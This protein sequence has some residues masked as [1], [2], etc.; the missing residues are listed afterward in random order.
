MD[1][2]PQ[3]WSRFSRPHTTHIALHLHGLD[4]INL[5]LPLFAASAS[6]HLPAVG[7]VSLWLHRF[8]RLSAHREHDPPGKATPQVPRHNQR[9]NIN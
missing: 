2:I 4:R 1:P 8:E 9:I 3:Q 7:L 6:D 5:L